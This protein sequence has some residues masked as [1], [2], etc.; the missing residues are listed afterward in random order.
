MCKHKKEEKAKNRT[1]PYH[2]YCS[3]VPPKAQ[4]SGL[5]ILVGSLLPPGAPN[6]LMSGLDVR[7]V[8]PA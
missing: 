4:I 1:S 7:L 8:L 6:R 3:S 2:I 5:N